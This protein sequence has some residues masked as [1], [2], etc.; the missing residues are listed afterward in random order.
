M[1][2]DVVFQKEDLELLFLA[3]I[4]EKEQLEPLALKKKKKKA[5]VLAG[6]T[7]CGKS[8]MAFMLAKMIKGEIISADSI[9]VYKG[10]DIGTAKVSKEKR[11]E[12]PHHLIDI[13]EVSESFNV[14]DFYYEASRVCQHILDRGDVPIIA[15]GSG[16]YIHALLYGPPSGPPSVPE[17]REKIQR[18]LQ[19]V[20]SELMYEK[21]KILDP[22]YA[23]TITIHDQQKIVRAL[24]IIELTG[25]RVS[26]YSWSTLSEEPYDFRCWFL[27][28]PRSTLYKRIEKRCDKML[29]R[30][31]LEEVAQLEKKGLRL[32]PS[33]S[34]AIG[35]RQSLDFLATPQTKEDWLRFVEEFKKASRHYVKRQ[36]TWFRNKEHLF[37]W[38]DLD[39]HDPETALNMIVNDF[40]GF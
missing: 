17:V 15:G 24:E 16:F 33:A 40:Y 4:V 3:G 6:P 30:G 23:S 25:Q 14:V 12:V 35:Y 11:L 26:H 39:R 29:A 13:R 1:T 37:R 20:G 9:Q 7:A 5:I 22:C 2:K 34:Q 18:E 21:L 28:R 10:M 27:N 32:N 38:L 31:L 8:E 36:L 19:K